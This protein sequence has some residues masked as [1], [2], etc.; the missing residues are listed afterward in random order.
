MAE[1]CML[2]HRSSVTLSRC[3]VHCDGSES[4][5]ADSS[6]ANPLTTLTTQASNVS[7]LAADCRSRLPKD[8]KSLFTNIGKLSS[9]IDKVH[10]RHTSGAD[11]CCLRRRLHRADFLA[12]VL[13]ACV[14]MLA[15]PRRPVPESALRVAGIPGGTRRGGG[16]SCQTRSRGGRRNRSRER[17]TIRIRRC[18]RTR[19]SAASVGR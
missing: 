2:A 18:W 10:H 5:T 15:R 1:R 17:R 8:F 11:C 3:A 13:D 19:A 16:G 14:D 6:S 12:V 9:K 4:L 7:R